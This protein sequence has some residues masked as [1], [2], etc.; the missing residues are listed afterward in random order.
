[1][2]KWFRLPDLGRDTFRQLM[3]AGVKYDKKFGF[4][5]TG[6]SNIPRVISILTS[7][8]E[9]EFE[10]SRSCYLCDGPIDSTPVAERTICDKCMKMPGSYLAYREKFVTRMTKP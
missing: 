10:L 7:A 1:M 4:R 2:N 5:L 9:E 8:L 6:E 3:V